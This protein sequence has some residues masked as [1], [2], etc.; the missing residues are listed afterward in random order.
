MRQFLDL[1]SPSRFRLITLCLIIIAV[2]GIYGASLMG[3]FVYDDEAQIVDNPYIKSFAY[4]PKAFTSCIWEASLPACKNYTLYYRPL[5]S[6]SYIFT[7]A[8]SSEPWIF[9][10]VNLAYYAIFC[11]LLFLLLS[12]L[13]KNRL[14]VHTV[15]FLFLLHPIHSEVVIWIGAVPELLLGIFALLMFL[16]HISH[17]RYKDWLTP[18]FYF[19]ALL[20]KETAIVLPVF[21]ILYDYFAKKERI[22]WVYIKQLWRFGAMFAIYLAMRL[23][24][25]GLPAKR[26]GGQ[27]L[28]LLERFYGAVYALG[29]YI[30]KTIYPHGFNLHIPFEPLTSALDERLWPAI[31]LCVALLIFF[32]YGLRARKNIVILGLSIFALFLLP[33]LIPMFLG[34]EYLIA[35]RYLF[36]PSLGFA[37]I[38][39]TYIAQFIEGKNRAK[40]LAAGFFLC[41]ILVLYAK[42]AY[43]QN[44]FWR[45]SKVLYEHVHAQN[46]KRGYPVDSVY[47]NLALIAEKEGDMAK[48]RKI[49]EEIIHNTKDIETRAEG[50]Y[51]NLGS[52]YYEE[53]KT[54]EAIELFKKAV[55]INKKHRFAFHNLAVALLDK[56][57]Y[58]DAVQSDIKA[59]GVDLGYKDPLEHLRKIYSEVVALPFYANKDNGKKFQDAISEIFKNAT[60]QK[61]EYNRVEEAKG[62]VFGTPFLSLVSYP[63]MVS[64][65]NYIRARFSAHPLVKDVLSYKMVLYAVDGEIKTFSDGFKTFRFDSNSNEISLL[66]PISKNEVQKHEVAIYF[67][68]NDFRYYK[69]PVSLRE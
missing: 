33:P 65:G 9:H 30:K 38:F 37:I 46:V 28:H 22:S 47:F 61:W 63:K 13:L 25:V 31:A 68:L 21:L 62:R 41:A 55:E 54:D 4:L 45:S 42:A 5:H 52:I 14:V 2:L 12:A 34:G 8:V 44:I 49:Y 6:L 10:L 60:W 43:A 39:G 40:Q 16:A 57:M 66:L 69:F 32:A 56:R 67:V 18:I 23:Y 11:Y 58:A 3:G 19:L 20:S 53:G 7:Y 50:A 1:L 26:I 35:E 17:S 29:E 51:N 27:E 36:L 59:L 15:L 24:A 64:E 48:A